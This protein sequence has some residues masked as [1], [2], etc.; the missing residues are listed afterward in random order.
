MGSPD[1]FD[2]VKDDIQASVSFSF[3]DCPGLRGHICVAKTHASTL[4]WLSTRQRDSF[5]AKYRRS[6]SPAA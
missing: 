3:D 2:L 6:F 4:T 1:P 5:P